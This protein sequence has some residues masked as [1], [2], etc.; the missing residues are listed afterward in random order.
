LLDEKLFKIRLN[1]PYGELKQQARDI[2]KE[3]G[4]SFEDVFKE[5]QIE[6]AMDEMT[7]G[8]EDAALAE[9]EFEKNLESLKKQYTE[10]AGLGEET[11]EILIGGFTAS[12]L[13]LTDAEIAA[14]KEMREAVRGDGMEDTAEKVRAALAAYG[15]SDD[16]AEALNELAVA[17]GEAAETS[18]DALV[19]L[20]QSGEELVDYMSDEFLEGWSNVW[21]GAVNIAEE[22]ANLI[23]EGLEETLNKV[24]KG[25]NEFISDYN[26]IARDLGLD[27]IGK[28][29][30]VDLGG[31]VEFGE[32]QF[33]VVVESNLVLDGE[34]AARA[35]NEANAN[36]QGYV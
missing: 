1:I 29:G 18:E 5:L 28:L 22:A 24:V 11:T 34:V 2:A 31:R 9:Q 19:A 36:N 30:S 10:L 32:I 33:A 26:S 3:T 20:E 14:F 6:A 12:E 8:F 23:Q 13:G 17:T 35:V 7:G 4:R 15:E 21:Q 16:A 27:T 25:I